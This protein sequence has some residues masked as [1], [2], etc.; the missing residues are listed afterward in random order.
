MGVWG[1]ASL[2]CGRLFVFVGLCLLMWASLCWCGGLFVG[3]GVSLS[4]GVGAF[5]DVGVSLWI[6]AFL[7]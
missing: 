6:W 5:V 1:I 3:V 4:L 2:W 7:C